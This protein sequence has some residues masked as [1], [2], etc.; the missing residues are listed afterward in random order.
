M[1]D[2]HLWFF[3]VPRHPTDEFNSNHFFYLIG[4]QEMISWTYEMMMLTDWR[5][6]Y[7]YISEERSST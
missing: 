2:V 6:T 4:I 3:V 1:N 7:A 5:T